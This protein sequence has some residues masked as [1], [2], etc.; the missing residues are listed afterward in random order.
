MCR[1]LS[2]HVVSSHALCF[3][4]NYYRQ[5]ICP[6]AAESPNT[7]GRCVSWLKSKSQNSSIR[8]LNVRR[9][10]G[11][12]IYGFLPTKVSKIGTAQLSPSIGTHRHDERKTQ[13]MRR[14]QIE[15][16][17]S[18]WQRDAQTFE[19]AQQQRLRLIFLY[20][21]SV[22]SKSWCLRATQKLKTR[23]TSHMIAPPLY[24]I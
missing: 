8:T 2:K 17:Q 11:L 19:L 21:C 24:I 20:R 22:S 5:H 18:A 13:Q 1:D 12:K 23:K 6:P 14:Q 4:S 16:R 9:Y 10:P 15:P 7:N 3:A